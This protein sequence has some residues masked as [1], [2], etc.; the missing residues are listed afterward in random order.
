MQTTKIQPIRIQRHVYLPAFR[1]CACILG[2]KEGCIYLAIFIFLA[3]FISLV[4]IPE[5]TFK[6]MTRTTATDLKGTI[7]F[8]SNP[9]GACLLARST[10]CFLF[11]LIEFYI[12]AMHESGVAASSNKIYGFCQNWIHTVSSQESRINLYVLFRLIRS[13]KYFL[14]QKQVILI[15]CL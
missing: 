6:T 13:V 5:Y 7:Q 11:M 1:A 15:W 3:S 12:L 2:L 4:K 14:K 10:C 8:S 9:N